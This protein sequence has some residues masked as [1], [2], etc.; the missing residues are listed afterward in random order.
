MAETLYIQTTELVKLLYY[1]KFIE[2]S[3]NDGIFNATHFIR[4]GGRKIFDTGID[5]R[6]VSWNEAEFVSFYEKSF[7]K[8]DQILN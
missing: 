3:L 2:A 1:N 8:I 7:W 5:S 4:F 6:E